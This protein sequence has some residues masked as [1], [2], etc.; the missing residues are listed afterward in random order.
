MLVVAGPEDV[1]FATLVLLLLLVQN[2]H[3][4]LS[5][6][7]SVQTT[8]GTVGVYHLEYCTLLQYKK[9]DFKLEFDK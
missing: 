8:V 5:K 6:K 3:V 2:V 9:R 7:Q 4:F 1:A